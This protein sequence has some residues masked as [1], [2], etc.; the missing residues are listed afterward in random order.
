MTKPLVLTFVGDDRPGLVNAIA[1]KVAG[2]GATWLESRSARLAGKFAGVVLVSVPDD[3]VIRTRIV[4]ARSRAMPGCASR[5][6]AARPLRP[7]NRRGSS[8]STSL[9]ASGRASCAT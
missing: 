8:L 7:R 3:R 2:C 9:A 5:S 6:S 1:E 4:A